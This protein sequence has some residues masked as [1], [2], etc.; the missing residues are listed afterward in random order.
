MFMSV[1]FKD[2]DQSS[3]KGFVVED[4]YKLVDGKKHRFDT[5]DPIID[6]INVFKFYDENFTESVP[7]MNSSSYD[8]FFMDGD[9]WVAKTWYGLEYVITKNIKTFKQLKQYYLEHTDKTT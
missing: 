6:R 7:C 2:G 5:G 1:D 9:K 3:Y 4:T 8:H